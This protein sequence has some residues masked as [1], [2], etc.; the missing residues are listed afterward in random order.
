MASLTVARSYRGRKPP[1]PQGILRLPVH[2]VHRIG[3]L[4]EGLLALPASA[5]AQS[6]DGDFTQSFR[7]QDCEWK[8]SGR[9][10]YFI[11][12]PGRRLVFEG[13]DEG[14]QKRLLVTVL[15]ETRPITL[16]IGG[17][18]RTV[19]TRVVEERE[20]S[21]GVLVEKSRNFFAICAPTND[22]FYFGETVNIYA[23]GQPV[24][25]DGA[26]LAGQEGAKPGIIMPGRF[27]LGARYFQEQ[28]PGIAMDQAEHTRMGLT[29]KKTALGTLKNCVEVI[30][31]T[32]LEPGES[33]KVYCPGIGLVIDNEVRLVEIT[34]VP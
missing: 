34:D 27:L 12:V 21:D 19:V 20:Y 30:E 15:R 2:H 32:P 9:N 4:A 24:S 25:H 11:L 1:G 18:Q 22:V 3:F 23:P 14:V 8:A 10:P 26:W 28:A 5:L 7:L 31:T 6:G 17:E 33:R 13:E 16:D 29:I